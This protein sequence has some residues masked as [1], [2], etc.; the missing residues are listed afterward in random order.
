MNLKIFNS[1]Y[2]RYDRYYNYFWDKLI[3]CIS[4]YHNVTEF[5][6]ASDFYDNSGIN[7]I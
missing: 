3:D 5:R 1:E 7:Q 4:K 2:N 6:D